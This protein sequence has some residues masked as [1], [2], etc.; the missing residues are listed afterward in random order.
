MIF[1][2]AYVEK[3]KLNGMLQSFLWLLLGI[4]LLAVFE[5]APV[6]VS[7]IAGTLLMIQGIGQLIL[8]IQ[9]DE[10]FKYS[11][12]SLGHC[13]CACFLGTWS[14]TCP[15][16]AL[17]SMYMILAFITLLHG[18]EDIIISVRLRM[19]KFD[20]WWIA[21]IFTTIAIGFS[22]LLIIFPHNKQILMFTS[23]NMILN[24]LC[25]FWMWRKLEKMAIIDMGI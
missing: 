19:L 4:I 11:L 16:E 14:L 12:L 5:S 7:Y 10:R 6:E 8:F 13:I 17:Q 24:A 20:K 1:T 25:D 21:A 18:I 3:L 22:L 23:F 2:K 15:R 9:E